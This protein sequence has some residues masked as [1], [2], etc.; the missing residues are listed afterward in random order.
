MFAKRLRKRQT[1]HE[2]LLWQKL[3]AKRFHDYKF[4]RQVPIG[5]F[6]VDFLCF[7]ARLVIEVDGYSH[8]LPGAQEYD[9]MREEYLEERGFKILRFGNT[10]VHESLEDVLKNIESF[11]K[12][13]P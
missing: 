4:K 5:P 6:I 9:R 8:W 11:L 3:R 7:E 2:A 13:S 12:P 1:I 10:D